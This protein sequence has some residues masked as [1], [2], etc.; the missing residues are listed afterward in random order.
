MAVEEASLNDFR[1][2]LAADA[3]SSMDFNENQWAKITGFVLEDGGRLRS[4]WPLQ[5]VSGLTDVEYLGTYQGYDGTVFLAAVKSTGEIVWAV[6]PSDSLPSGDPGLTLTWN[7]LQNSGGATPTG[8]GPRRPLCNVPLRTES[9][10]GFRSGLL[11]NSIDLAD[12]DSSVAVYQED[13]SQTLRFTEKA[14]HWPADTSESVMPK[15]EHGVVWN[16]VLVLGDI[17]WKDDPDSALSETNK[18]RARNGLFL[19]EPGKPFTYD[20]LNVLFI[21]DHHSSISGL[22]GIDAGLLVFT[23]NR[24]TGIGGI[25]LLRGT[26][27]N[28]SLETVRE[29]LGADHGQAVW[30]QTGT[31]VWVSSDGEVWQTNGQRAKRVDVQGLGV[32]RSA[33]DKDGVHEFGPWA[34]VVR[35]GRMFALRDLGREGAWTELA[36]GGIS[37][38][39]SRGGGQVGQAFYFVT[40][41]GTNQAIW[42]F[43]RDDLDSGVSERGGGT[44]GVRDLSLG[45]RTLE[46]GAGHNKTMWQA[47]GVRATAGEDADTADLTKLEL[48]AGPVRDSSSPQLDRVPSAPHDLTDGGT[49]RQRFQ[50]IYRGIGPANEFSAE[51]VFQGDVVLEQ[52][53]VMYRPGLLGGDEEGR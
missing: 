26:P 35:D 19:S 34:L 5:Q 39:F 29:G 23:D 22:Q 48:R 51:A 44:D 17:E 36:L 21:G 14:D 41:D 50:V 8:S 32:D 9:S 25:Y 11:L 38:D 6:A 43:T 52:V 12:G 42:R 4:Q 2:G 46:S 27:D 33:Q 40:D 53:S 31:A 18:K 7:S 45:T 30:Q 3:R 47:V 1:G 15:G 13:G 10:A 37:P 28:Y 49:E 24:E 20:P 16:G